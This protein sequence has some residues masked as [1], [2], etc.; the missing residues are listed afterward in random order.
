MNLFKIYFSHGR[1]SGPNGKK[2]GYL[3]SIAEEMNFKTE[4]IDYR[5]TKD[6]DY[7]VNILLN[8]CNNSKENII[9]YGSSMGAYVSLAASETIK[10]KGLFLCAPALFIPGYNLTEFV[11]LNIPVTIVHGYNDTII[12]Y[13][14]SVKYAEKQQCELHIVNDDHSLS[15]SQ[16]VISFLFK[17][18]L[19]R[20]VAVKRVNY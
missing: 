8:S 2:I 4:S 5:S 17:D 18:F 9:L 12:S 3:N 19:R 11:N 10:P 16:S 15:N 14:N 20:I 6:P 7:R 13:K 1:D